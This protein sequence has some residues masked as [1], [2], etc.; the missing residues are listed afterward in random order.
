MEPRPTGRHASLTRRVT[1]HALALPTALM[2]IGLGA[3]SPG[4]QPS[5]EP[6]WE[7]PVR[8]PVIRA[9]DAPEDPF[10]AGHRGIDIAAPIGTAVVAPAAGTVAFA[11]RIGGHLFVT[12]DH[13]GELTTTYSWI[14]ATS[15]RE[16]DFV[17]AGQ[18]FATTGP[19]HPGSA[20]PHLHF[21]VRLAGAYLDPLEYLPDLGVVDL[22]RLA[23]LAA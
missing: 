23:P 20:V 4:V 13:G 1:M 11:G 10:G 8:G 19:G 14:S 5:T 7:W 17:S 2:V 18:P 16:G 6:G 21:G 3:A 15:V 12:L 22:I 9:F